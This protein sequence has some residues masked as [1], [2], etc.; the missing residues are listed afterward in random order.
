LAKVIAGG[1]FSG[2][3]LKAKVAWVLLGSQAQ[4]GGRVSL[5]VDG[6][7]ERVLGWDFRLR[8]QASG[9]DFQI[10]PAPGEDAQNFLGRGLQRCRRGRWCGP[11]QMC[12]RR[13]GG[14]AIARLMVLHCLATGEQEQSHGREINAD[15]TTTTAIEFD[16][17][18]YYILAKP[19]RH[20]QII[21]MRRGFAAD[22]RRRRI[23]HDP[24]RKIRATDGFGLG[25][26]F[27]AR[28]WLRFAGCVRG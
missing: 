17:G 14:G 8:P 18:N 15:A 28:L 23:S 16:A 21:A 22:R 7:Q 26:A 3:D 9:G 20:F 10:L 25:D 1:R 2:F 27:S 4:K 24:V 11:F 12:R 19:I 13:H 5:F 6:H